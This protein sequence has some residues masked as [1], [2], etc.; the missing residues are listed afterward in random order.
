MARHEVMPLLAESAP[1]PP[2]PP[3]KD[4]LYAALGRST[5][6]QIARARLPRHDPSPTGGAP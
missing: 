4:Q 3:K 5:P 6:Q 1:S 2:E